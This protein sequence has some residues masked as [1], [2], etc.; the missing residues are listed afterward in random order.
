M[1]IGWIFK[2]IKSVPKVLDYFTGLGPVISGIISIS[3]QVVEPLLLNVR[4][5][6]V[7]TQQLLV[8]IV[9]NIT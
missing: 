5:E 8:G 6:N 3:K 4:D 7:T 9:S 1:N 2:A